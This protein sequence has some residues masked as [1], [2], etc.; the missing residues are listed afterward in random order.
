MCLGGG[1]HLLGVQTLCCVCIILW[2]ATVTF[3]LLFLINKVK[4]IRMSAHEELL[5]ADLVDHGIRHQG[6]GLSRTVSALRRH[7]E[8]Y[9][10]LVTELPPEVGSNLGGCHAAAAN[11]CTPVSFRSRRWS[12]ETFYSYITS[13]SSE[14]CSKFDNS[15]LLFLRLLLTSYANSI[16]LIRY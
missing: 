11:V 15:S 4:P 10:K 3:I 2:S 7:S 12:F 8:I 14:T 9:P 13:L 1:W 6:L 16:S 5:G